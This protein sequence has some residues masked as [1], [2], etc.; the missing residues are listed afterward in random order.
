MLGDAML[1]RLL[2]LIGAGGTAEALSGP[3]A[4]TLAAAA[5]LVEAA[6][7][8]G[9]VAPDERRAIEG[10]LQRHFGL[11]AHAVAEVIAKGERA[12]SGANHLVR[13]TRT[14]KDRFDEAER[15]ALMELLWEVVQA[16]GVVDHLESN[17]MRR[18]A[19][20]IYVT[21]QDSGA[22]RKR[23]LER[24]RANAPAKPW[25]QADD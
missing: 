19:G 7:I 4:K 18:I 16:D 8:D 17:L 2:G 23:A 12:Q 1:D 24:R 22:A 25:G 11:S 6:A 15:V 3:D 21:D 5:L 9:Q 14:I 10:V 13:F 20:L